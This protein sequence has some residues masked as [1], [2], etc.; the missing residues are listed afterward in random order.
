MSKKMVISDLDGTLVYKG[1]SFNERRFPELLR[2]LQNYGA[3]FG[4]ATGRSRAELE[5]LIAPYFSSVDAVLCDG[6]CTFRGGR[7]V[8][9]A[10]IEQTVLLSIFEHTKKNRCVLL[11]HAADTAYL[12]GASFVQRSREKRRLSEVYDI[13][14]IS[15]VNEPIYKI[16]LYGDNETSVSFPSLRLAYAAAGIREYVDEHASKLS[17]VKALLSDSG[18][19][20][21][22]LTYFGD[23]E[24]DAELL[25]SAARSFT[26]YC[27]APDVF[28]LAREHT[29]DV[30]GTIIR[31][32]DEKTL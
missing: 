21:S 27:A 23:G 1:S 8:R 11:L 7:F 17:A 29:R 5:P 13:S 15:A 9:G 26:P 32:C 24:N 20:L 6:A 19:S 22:E 31:L 12:Y 2:K 10:A 3:F 4:V 14:D 16:A 28:P 25:R 18:L 30:I